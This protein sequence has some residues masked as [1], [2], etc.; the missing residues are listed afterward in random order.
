MAAK[1]LSAHF[2]GNGSEQGAYIGIPLLVLL[3]IACVVARRRRALW[4]GFSVAAGTALLS[5]GPTL[6]VAG[7]VSGF[8]LPDKY[9]Q[10]LPFFHNLLPDRFALVMFLGVGFV[11]AVGLSELEHAQSPLKV[12][13]WSLGLLGLAAIAPLVTYPT[14]PSP[15][16]AAFSTGWACPRGASSHPA[17]VLVLPA[18]DEMALRWQAEAGFCYT[19]PSDA[20]MTGSNSGDVGRQSLLL[21]VGQSGFPLPALTPPVREEAAGDIVRLGITEIVVAP[22]SP[23]QPMMTPT[24]QAQLVTWVTNLLGQKPAQN[25]D[26]FL[27]AHLPSPGSIAAGS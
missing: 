13:C 16:L 15:N 12:V 17:S 9:L 21:S 4:V 23:S 19:M 11:L 5:M 1:R 7:H 18:T 6:H 20:G 8:P 22:A 25:G 2:T 10:D 3:V 24:G 14:V 27:W 26:T